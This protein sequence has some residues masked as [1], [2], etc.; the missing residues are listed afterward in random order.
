MAGK[1][2]IEM[3]ATL[4]EL[5]NPGLNPKRP[6]FTKPLLPPAVGEKV[7]SL[8][9]EEIRKIRELRGAV[10]DLHPGMGGVAPES[11]IRMIQ[12]GAKI[13]SL[14][15]MITKGCNFECTWCF[16]ESGPLMKEYLP[17]NILERL[18]AEG[19]ESGV[20]LFVLTGGEPLMYRDPALGKQGTRGIHFFRIV[21][22]IR[23]TAARMGTP[24]KILTF[25]DVALITPEIAERFAEF[26][27]GL[28]TKGDTL[29]AE[30]QEYK[31][32]QSGAFRKIQEGYRNLMNAGYGR[33]QK[34]RLVVNSVL[35]HTTFDGMIDLHLWVMEN[36][37]DH[38]IV[39][40][41]YCGNAED[42]DQEAG[43]HSPHVKVLY[44]LLARID[45]KYF[46]L[47]WTP[48]SAF[49]YNK[50]CNRNRSGLHIRASGDVTA[51]SESPD[52]TATDRYT[53]GN[54][55][56][57]GFSL[58]SLA[59]SE[60]L[61]RYRTEFAEG[62]GTYVCSPDVCDLYANDLCQGGCATRSAYSKI[63]TESGLIIK[64]DNHHN[65]SEKREDP[66][67]PAWTVL[68]ERQNVLR[69]GLLESIHQRL[70][71]KTARIEAVD[72]PYQV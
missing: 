13:T 23:E 27:V 55:F 3:T 49:T 69:Q 44:D 8:T 39:P 15:F 48:W 54:V 37:F 58:K 50:S 46:E 17:F 12:D 25:D 62:H 20:Q 35:D 30:L 7:F 31:V 19:L 41:H 71:A 32:N 56:D 1:N 33:D 16:A 29:N 14:D 70:L 67:C 6:I 11:I 61:A 45:S 57:D 24:T 18:T 26:E 51:C 47:D 53:F 5:I 4:R 34:L 42:E 36:G 66:L 60:R 63:D 21:E 9:P 52:R 64:N 40:V 38:S 2:R 65:Y 43:I 68:A 59:G 28:C 22:M 72:F 10:V